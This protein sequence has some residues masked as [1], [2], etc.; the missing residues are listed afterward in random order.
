MGDREGGAAGR[1][2]TFS[3]ALDFY[4][5][6]AGNIRNKN[7]RLAALA[8][9]NP[10]RGAFGQ[11]SAMSTSSS[12]LDH[13]SS[14]KVLPRASVLDTTGA[15]PNSPTSCPR[16][17]WS[18]GAKISMGPFCMPLSASGRA[19]HRGSWTWQELVPIHPVSDCP[20]WEFR[21]VTHPSVLPLGQAPTTALGLPSPVGISG[22]M[23]LWLKLLY[24]LSTGTY[25]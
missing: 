10:S 2:V 19:S 6:F 7:T 11:H 17:S 18:L 14:F 23:L 5:C 1:W 3:N 25:P 16:V 13:A 9:L 15:H 24:Q 8:T 12:F 21:D 22:H 20:V 4:L